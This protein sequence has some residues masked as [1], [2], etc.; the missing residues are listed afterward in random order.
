MIRGKDFLRWG[1]V[2]YL[3]I[4]VTETNPGEEN[5]GIGAVEEYSKAEEERVVT[6][7]QSTTVQIVTAADDFDVPASSRWDRATKRTV[8]VL[9]IIVICA[10]LW[11]SRAVLPII[12]FAGIIAYLLSPIVDTLDR[13]RIPRSLSTI[14]LFFLL[15]IGFIL[16]PV[17]LIPV[18]LNQLSS[19]ANYNPQ[20]I[21][22]DVIEWL[23]TTLDNL[24]DSIIVPILGLEFPIGNT[25]QE[26]QTN[27]QQY[28][29]IPT[30]A[31]LLNY[32]QQVIG[33]TTSVVSSTAVFGISVVGGIVQFLFTFL[34]IFFTSLYL[35][36]DAPK[37]RSYVQSLFPPSYQPEFG[38]LLRRISRIW[39]A[40][41]RGQIVLCLF[42][43]TVTWI[44]LELA[45]MP[46]A[47][48]LGAVAGVL[49]IVPNLGPT[50][51]MLP[52]VVVALIQ[53]SEVLGPLGIDN[54]SFAL[55]T[56]AIYFIIQQLENNIIVPRIIGDSVNLHPIVVICGVVVG[57]NVGG[58]LG[59]FLAAPVVASLRVMGGYIHA[60]LLDYPPFE[61]QQYRPRPRLWSYR[62]S[63]QGEDARRL[64]MDDT[65][66]SG[67][68]DEVIDDDSSGPSSLDDQ[69]TPTATVST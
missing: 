23:G 2:V 20:Q 13:L 57:F 53:G 5:N 34:V 44:S 37:I 9:M 66:P 52:A 43:G 63:G 15:L 58:L 35:T 24:P 64:A 51:A 46:G 68:H 28:L 31:E 29:V 10:L 14:V 25:M 30:I 62:R 61:E 8:I 60:K 17:L 56:I 1:C 69:R 40:F 49:E 47:L 6:P 4:A 33:T 45:G 65:P 55:I 48:I 16:L 21:T 12:I 32:M 7:T 39:Q 50:L 22:R 36:K 11:M 54:V 19:L 27:F 38:E 67:E 42:I 3:Y 41:F 18:L 59:A 26:L